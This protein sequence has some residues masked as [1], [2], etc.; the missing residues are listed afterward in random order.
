MQ[1]FKK[2][3][4]EAERQV[5]IA[6][7]ELTEPIE[8]PNNTHYAFY[9][10][11]LEDAAAYF[12]SLR[13]DWT[14]A[15]TRLAECG[16]LRQ[17]SQGY[18]LTEVGA[19]LAR[20]ER[21][22]HPPI[23]YWY[24]EYYTITSRSRAYSRFCEALYGRDLCQTNFSDMA[25]LDLLIQVADLKSGDRVLDL[26]CGKGL[27]AEYLSDVTGA[28]AWGVDYTPK[29]IQQALERTS[30]KRDRLD[31]KVGNLDHL[32]YTAGSFDCLV[33]IDTIYMPNNLPAT[34]QVLRDLLAPGGKM[35][36]FYLSML[37]DPAQPRELLQPDHNDMAR[38]LNQVGLPY[39][40]IDLTEPT[41]H[42]MRRK[43]SLAQSM[44]PEFEAEGTLFLYDHLIA[45]SDSGSTPFDPQTVMLSRY[46]YEIGPC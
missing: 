8:T 9:P 41:F 11:T 37:F 29:A 38:V 22:D 35:L 19:A 39:R 20:Q 10:K 7:I 16:M 46:L 44:R 42:L 14:S 23:W 17:D 40:T 1:P 27:F 2:S 5:L 12:H 13:E 26:G 21:L 45:E 18:S 28:R 36:I 34:F 33:S 3:L 30:A 15:N 24:R 4:T 31:F 43:H 32:D 25:Q 6:F